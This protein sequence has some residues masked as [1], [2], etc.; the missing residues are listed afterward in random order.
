MENIL[1][2]IYMMSILGISIVTDIL[3]GTVIGAKKAKFKP[4]KFFSGIGKGVLITLCMVLICATLELVPIVLARVNIEVPS[5]LI[6]VVELVT[7]G[8]TA[9]KKYI[10]DC[11]EKIKNILGIEG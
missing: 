2:I 8:L 3:L 4:K 11:I 10:T 7:I 9:Y 6:T 1:T 5:D